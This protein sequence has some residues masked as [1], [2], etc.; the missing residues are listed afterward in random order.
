MKPSKRAFQAR[1]EPSFPEKLRPRDLSLDEFLSQESP[2]EVW[3]A[4]FDTLKSIKGDPGYSPSGGTLGSWEDV[5]V[6]TLESLSNARQT[7]KTPKKLKLGPM[8][9]PA[10]VPFKNSRG[11]PL[12]EVEP[13]WENE[14]GEILESKLS[15]G[16]QT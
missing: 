7:L 11:E 15:K 3:V 1:L 8:L 16:E 2:Y 10:N 9:S 4:Y 6:P 13:I 14:E 5:D 12:S